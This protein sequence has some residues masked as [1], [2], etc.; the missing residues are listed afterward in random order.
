ML[1]NRTTPVDIAATMRIER[2]QL[3][4][5]IAGMLSRLKVPVASSTSQ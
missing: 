1:V 4:R 3:D 5:R 2:V